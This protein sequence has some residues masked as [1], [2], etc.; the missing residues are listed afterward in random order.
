[1]QKNFQN[2]LDNL[3]VELTS[4]CNFRCQMCDIWQT[5]N[6]SLPFNLLNK[7]LK[8]ARDL[9]ANQVSF[10]GGEP[11][12]YPNFED[13]LKLAKGLGFNV[14]VSTNGSL[15]NNQNVEFLTHFIDHI[16]ISI[17]GNRKTH[18]KLR[19]QG[20][21]DKSLR[22]IRLL[23]KKKILI[24]LSMVVSKQ[25]FQRMKSLVDLA[26]KENVYQ[27]IFQPFI[28]SMLF[29][30]PKKSQEFWIAKND[31]IKLSKEI[32]KTVNYAQK[33]KVDILSE[34]L[35][36]AI[37]NYFSLSGKIYPNRFCHIAQT[38]LVILKDGKVALCWGWAN[39]TL[40]NVEKNSLS[41]IFH[42]SKRREIL[43]MIEQKKCPGCLSACSDIDFYHSTN[44][45]NFR[46]LI[47]KM[48]RFY[49]ISKF[50]G[51]S[52]GFSILK[53]KILRRNYK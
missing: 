25:S 52:Y 17:E 31:L 8:Q 20:N 22:A 43:R 34:N 28:K 46:L 7:A 11:L 51:L 14:F 30:R 9:G 21:Y 45:N 6:K 3:Y 39:M 4:N 42:G 48:N 50:K 16:G 44:E 19:G 37:P 41:E 27:I 12:L 13:A 26:S 36:R 38:S 33:K 29:K 5:K 1:M 24:S 53:S 32:E 23:K 2:G 40:G 10:S 15:I 49:R 47:K 18:E 35:F